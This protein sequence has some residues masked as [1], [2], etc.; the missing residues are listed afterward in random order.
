MTAA[1]IKVGDTIADHQSPSLDGPAAVEHLTPQWIYLC[2]LHGEQA[3]I[4]RPAY[5]ARRCVA[6]QPEP[7]YHAVSDAHR[8]LL[9]EARGRDGEPRGTFAD[10]IA[11][12]IARLEDA[13]DYAAQG[14][15][16]AALLVFDHR[17]TS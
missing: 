14:D 12:L 11:R 16:A 15:H 4:D 7:L 1:P 10:Q 3:P 13:R 2:D 5:E 8:A 6:S 17:V 9:A